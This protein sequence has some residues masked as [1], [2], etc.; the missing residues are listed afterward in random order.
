MGN[1]KRL[2]NQYGNLIQEVKKELSNLHVET[3]EKCVVYYSE[4][5]WFPGGQFSLSVIHNSTEN[6][7]TLITKSWDHEYDCKRFSTGVYNLDR[8]C[9]K[10]D[11]IR[12]SSGQQKQFEAIIND[13]NAIPETI[14]AEGYII[15]DGVEYELTIQT[16]FIDKKYNWKLPSENLKTFTSLID[17]LHTNSTLKTQH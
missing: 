1:G 8:V 10:T 3:H 14:D 5:P 13:I 16:E 9:I 2:T 7:Y 11:T 15:L 4:I 17:F 6:N 12:L